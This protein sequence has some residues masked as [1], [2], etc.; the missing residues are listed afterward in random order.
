LHQ[1]D[2]K[3]TRENPSYACLLQAFPSETRIEKSPAGRWMSNRKREAYVWISERDEKKLFLEQIECYKERMEKQS[4]RYR[5][6]EFE[7]GGRNRKL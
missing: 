6:V 5:E 2:E 1:R 3:R 7:K 4:A